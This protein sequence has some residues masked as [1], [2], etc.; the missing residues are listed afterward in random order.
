MIPTMPRYIL[1]AVAGLAGERALM[2]W[3]F[4]F[5]VGTQWAVWL[6]TDLI[7]L[8][9]MIGQDFL[10]SCVVGRLGLVPMGHS[11]LVRFPVSCSH[12]RE[13]R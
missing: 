2:D 4:T 9:T 12:L 13:E 7:C 8:K 1:T 10:T 3:Q 11:N 5:V 6:S